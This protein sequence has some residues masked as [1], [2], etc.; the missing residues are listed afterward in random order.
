MNQMKLF[1]FTPVINISKPLLGKKLVPGIVLG[2]TNSYYDK[3]YSGGVFNV[4]AVMNYTF[5]K[6][7][8]FALSVLVLNRKD[9]PLTS[10][11]THDKRFTETTVMLNYSVN[12]ELFDLKNQINKV[13]K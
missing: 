2:Y 10:L 4:R 3:K 1:S 13:K 5:L 7:H 6:V 11:Y 12:L 9:N 8:R